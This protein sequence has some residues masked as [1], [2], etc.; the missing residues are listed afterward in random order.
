MIS[1]LPFV[2]KVTFTLGV[3]DSSIFLIGSNNHLFLY[4]VKKSLSFWARDTLRLKNSQLLTDLFC[5]YSTMAKFI[6]EVLI[7]EE[8]SVQELTISL[9]VIFNLHL[10]VAP[11]TNSTNTKKLLIL[12]QVQ[13][14]LSSKLKQDDF[15]TMDFLINGSQLLFL[16]KSRPKRFLPLNQA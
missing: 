2:T 10:L 16:Y 8:F 15:S 4:K 3:L 12:R 13:T 5:Y 14:L 1:Q 7:M 6:V 9:W 11:M